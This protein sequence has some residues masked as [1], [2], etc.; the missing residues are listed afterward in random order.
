MIVNET[1]NSES[2]KK[3]IS[4]EQTQ[5]KTIQE[6]TVDGE[7]VFTIVAVD[8]DSGRSL[9]ESIQNLGPITPIYYMADGVTLVDGFHRL[10][11]CPNAKYT[12]VV[13]KDVSLRL[14]GYFIAWRLTALEEKYPLQK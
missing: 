2:D 4:P 9:A 5:Y 7:K 12:K 6:K 3:T 13:L 1:S 8:D 14:I 10:T 11:E